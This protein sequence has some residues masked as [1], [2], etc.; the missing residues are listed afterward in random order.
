M[1][2]A[3][4]PLALG[5][6][7]RGQL[8]C[9]WFSGERAA[10]PEVGGFVDAPAG[11]GLGDAQPVGQSRAQLAAEFC[12]AGLRVELIDQLMLRGAQLAC[13]AFEVLQRPQ[14]FRGGQDIK[15]QLAQPVQAGVDH[16]ED[17]H[18]LLTTARTHAPKSTKDHRQES[19]RCDH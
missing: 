13:H 7:G 14:P 17:L 16:V 8:R 10:L 5:G 19:S 1:P 11:L 4:Q 2:L 12:F 6:R 15:G 9:Q 18:D 3:D